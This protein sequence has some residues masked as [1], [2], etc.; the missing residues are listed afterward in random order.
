M[1]VQAAWKDTRDS[2]PKSGTLA[3]GTPSV[4]L[5]SHSERVGAGLKPGPVPSQSGGARMSHSHKAG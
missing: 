2:E 4:R 1:M 5:G 3:T